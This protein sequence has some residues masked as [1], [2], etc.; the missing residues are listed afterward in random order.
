MDARK[1]RLLVTASTLGAVGWLG[2]TLLAPFLRDEQLRRELRPNGSAVRIRSLVTQGASTEI[3]SADNGHTP[4]MWA[5]RAGDV[6]L[7]SLLLRRRADPTARDM[8][9]RTA[10]CHAAGVGDLEI[11]R[12]LL[13][14]S[15]TAADLGVNEAAQ[16]AAARG[17]LEPLTLLLASGAD[18]NARVGLHG[19]TSL[20]AAVRREDLGSVRLLLSAGANPLIVD[21]GN[22]SPLDAAEA[23]VQDVIRHSSPERRL[24]C[25]QILRLLRKH[26]ATAPP[27]TDLPDTGPA[28]YTVGPR[29]RPG[30]P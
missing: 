19:G 13:A 27:M 11:L 21:A 10:L 12:L 20:A 2:T 26:A 28:T 15:A 23:R 18:P 16:I 17:K 6:S 14:Q 30:A 1:R 8:N 5:A 9:G 24:R 4:L 22:I 29:G 25:R 7:V 3:H